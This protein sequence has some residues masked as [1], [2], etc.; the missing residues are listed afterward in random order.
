MERQTDDRVIIVMCQ[1]VYPATQKKYAEEEFIAQYC[2]DIIFECCL[3][4]W[5]EKTI[6]VSWN[7]FMPCEIAKQDSASGLTHLFSV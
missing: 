3:D 6:F 7:E 4:A 2:V 5:N 1:P